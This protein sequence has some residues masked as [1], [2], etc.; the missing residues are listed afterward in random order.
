MDVLVDSAELS[1]WRPGLDSTK[2]CYWSKRV[3]QLVDP[4]AY[5]QLEFESTCQM[6]ALS[7]STR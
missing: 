6:I 1:E 7:L 5:S 3:H 4:Q 2:A